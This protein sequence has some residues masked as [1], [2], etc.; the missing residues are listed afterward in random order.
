MHRSEINIDLGAL[1]RNVRTVLRALDGSELWAVVKADGYGHGATD[2]AG[3]A[4]G[5]GAT[6]L[7]VATIPEGLSLR[8]EYRTER[9]IVMG[10]AGSN[11]E[12]AQARAAGLELAIADGEIPEGVRVHLKLDTGMG[13]YGLSE[14]PSPP[15][16]VVGLMTHLAT[17]DSDAGFARAQLERFRSATE[18]YKHLARHAANSA[19]A[20][21]L[22]ESHFD[23]A[24]CGIAI[25]GLSP[26]NTDPQEDGLEPV[27]SWQTAL[28]QVKRLEPGQSSGYGRRFIA[29]AA[30]WIGIV[31][32]GYADGFRRDLTGTEVR[33][34][35]ELRRVVG[36]VS[37]DSFAVEL[38]RE[39]PVGAPVVLLGH[40]V[41]AEAHGRVADTINYEVVCGIESGPLRA[42]RTVIDA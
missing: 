38:D 3:A 35:G 30:T 15:A 40:G 33:V 19:A 24:R 34:A 16:E 36:T 11:R 31:P 25:Y 14:L 1:R 6:A 27:L 21:R 39:L 10:P 23:A 18:Q 13:R 12:V 8:D 5:A 17:A 22:P 41:L 28:A 4:L 42:R 20:L 7:C 37:M 26:F 29:D 32:V 2:V 9:I